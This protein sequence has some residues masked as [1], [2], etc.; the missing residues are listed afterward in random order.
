M[1]ETTSAH[2]SR[3]RL[4]IGVLLGAVLSAV[5]IKW[6][7][8]PAYLDLSVTPEEAEVTLDGQPVSLADGWALIQESPGHHRLSIRAAG[9]EPQEKSMDL[10]R[11]RDNALRANIRL[12]SRQ[13]RLH[14]VSTPEGAAVEVLDRK[15][16]LAARGTTPFYSP[17][18]PQGDYTLRFTS[19]LCLAQEVR[20]TVPPEERTAEVPPVVLQRVGG[21]EDS[22]RALAWIRESWAPWKG[23]EF[24]DDPTLTFGQVLHYVAKRHD[25]AITI[26]ERAFQDEGLAAD[27]LRA[28]CPFERIFDL[29]PNA[30]QMCVREVLQRVL[31]RMVEVPS[32]MTLVPRRGGQRTYGWEVTTG[33]AA[34]CERVTVMHP[35]RDLL[36]GPDALSAAQLVSLVES[37][38]PFWVLRNPLTGEVAT[39][40]EGRP[41]PPTS[42]QFLTFAG[43]L[44][45]TDNWATQ[46]AVHEFLNQ[47]RQARRTK[48]VLPALLRPVGDVTESSRLLACLRDTWAPWK[49]PTCLDDFTMTFEEFLSKVARYQG[50]TVTINASAFAAEEVTEHSFRGWRPFLDEPLDLGPDAKKLSLRAVLRKALDRVTTPSGATVVPRKLAGNRYGLEVTTGQFMLGEQFTVLHPVGDFVGKGLSGEQLVR[51]VRA[52]LSF[53][54]ARNPITGMVPDPEKLPPRRET[55]VQFLPVGG[56]LRITHNWGVQEAVDSFLNQL[57]QSVSRR[58]TVPD[59]LRPVSDVT[60]SARLLACMRASW[61]PWKGPRELDGSRTLRQFLQIVG[62]HHGVN[63]TLNERAFEAD[64][65]AL[66]DKALGEGKVFFKQDWSA[67]AVLLDVLKGLGVTGGAALIP[68][69]LSE[70][71]CGWEITTKAAAEAEPF[72]VLHPAG[73]LLSGPGALS[74][75]QLM[76]TVRGQLP[77]RE[78]AVASVEFSP[79]GRAVVVSYNWRTQE[80]VDS[81]LNQ[82]RQVQRRKKGAP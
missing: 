38:M 71:T 47:L 40:E 8:R 34:F 61:V 69:K 51:A 19:D 25:I 36:T 29:R 35:A 10:L 62:R 12:Q 64:N 45:V 44:H 2:H 65:P 26:N 49:G 75:Q 58:G 39:P 76:A 27:K 37:Q 3:Q 43:A 73:D 14:A 20:A 5:A 60:E 15:G 59:M 24:Y 54:E 80:L 78:R 74:E 53:W 4:V 32:G 77:L 28:T 17:P 63:V 7:T 41:L 16:Q 72:T 6:Q 1:S 55:P 13:G 57:R 67:Q 23:F 56:V 50:V 52:Q 81:C 11:G 70:K 9:Y 68:R 18:L 30:K 46:E 66:L 33:A 48:G 21:A 22:I 31:D 82:L 42:I 79:P